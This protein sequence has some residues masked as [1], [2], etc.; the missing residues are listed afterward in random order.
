M[1]VQQQEVVISL[2]PRSV[3]D[4]LRALRI[5][6]IAASRDEGSPVCLE[7]FHDEASSIEAFQAGGS[8]AWAECGGRDG[9]FRTVLGG[10]EIKIR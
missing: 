9:G 7:R 1:T 8:D 6:W 5:R 4:A 3:H 2:C 10:M